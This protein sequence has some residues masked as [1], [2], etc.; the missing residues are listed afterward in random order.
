MVTRG[1]V[2]AAQGLFSS[3]GRLEQ[4]ARNARK[5]VWKGPAE[6]P[7]E[8]RARLW[9]AAKKASPQGCPIKGQ[10]SRNERLYFV[11]WQAGYQRVRIRADKGEKWFCS[12]QEAQAAG[13]RRQGGA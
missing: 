7:D 6:R 13:W 1:L 5:G 9:E 4:D 2:F 11:P 12:E 10:V 3:Y 8:Y